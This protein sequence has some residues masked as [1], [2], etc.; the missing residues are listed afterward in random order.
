MPSFWDDD[1][2]E[3]D[4]QKLEE[5]SLRQMK[6]SLLEVS[7]LIAKQL[8]QVMGMKLA[9]WMIG[10]CAPASYQPPPPLLG[11]SAAIW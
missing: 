7:V 2:T 6:A 10:S 3:E 11:Y 1:L 8:G 4:M 5:E 9:A